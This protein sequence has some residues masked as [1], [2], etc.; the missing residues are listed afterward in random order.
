MAISA[1]NRSPRFLRFAQEF[2][3]VDAMF[4]GRVFVEYEE[5]RRLVVAAIDADG[6]E[7]QLAP[8]AAAAWQ[9]MQNSAAEAGVLMF[10]ASAFRSVERQAEIVRRKLA[11]GQSIDQVLSVS[12]LPG[13]SEHHTGARWT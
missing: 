4:A 5:A 7:H 1:R 12:A 9:S 2:G 10:I 3:V 11:S 13:C 8:G 6:R